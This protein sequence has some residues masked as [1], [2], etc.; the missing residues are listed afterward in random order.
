M[1]PPSDPSTT[2]V[3]EAARAAVAH[4]ISVVPAAEDGT[5]RPAVA[6][7]VYRRRLPTQA[8]L[9]RWFRRERRAGLCFVCGEVSGGLEMLEFED[10]SVYAAYKVLA[11]ETGLE[12]LLERI[13][14]GFS[15]ASPGGGVHLVYRCDEVAANTVLAKRPKQLEERRDP[16][17]TDAVVAET[18]GEGGVTI[19][20]PSGGGVHPT[21]RPYRQLRG[22]VA[23]I[24]R[25]LPGERRELLGLVRT[26][27]RRQPVP[28]REP[29]PPRPTVSGTRPGDAYNDAA[30]VRA[31][32]GSHGWA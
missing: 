22:G 9:L 20:P 13:E 32:L 25:I 29:R 2:L 28:P 27:D 7:L 8:E 17:D 18:R 12:L 1:T 5:K 15:S 16:R 31:L 19:E 3:Y 10:R 24:A 30:D 4:G 21:G 11:E 14:A 6:W 23:T 26:L